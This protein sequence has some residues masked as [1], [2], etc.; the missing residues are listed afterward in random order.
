M[1]IISMII[2]YAIT[3]KQIFRKTHHHS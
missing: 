2:G 3:S 1:N